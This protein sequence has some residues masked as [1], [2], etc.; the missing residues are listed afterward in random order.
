MNRL[1]KKLKATGVLLGSAIAVAGVWYA[2]SA[3]PV[4]EGIYFGRWLASF[5]P[6]AGGSM[7]AGWLVGLLLCGFGQLVDNSDT[8]LHLM[9]Q[10][11]VEDDAAKEKE[12]M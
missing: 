5:L 2:V 10:K 8:S 9:M 7:L 6:I 12:S 4:G 3:A 11:A 1:G